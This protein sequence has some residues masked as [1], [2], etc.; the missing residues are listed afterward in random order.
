ML[1][2]WLDYH[3]ET[4]LWKCD[5]LTDEDMRR[6]WL[7]SWGVREILIHISG[8]HD[9][10]ATALGRVANGDAPYPE[11]TY[12]DFDA[13]N[14]RFVEQRE[15]VKTADVLAELQHRVDAM[16]EHRLRE[17]LAPQLA[18][19]ADDMVASAK[20]ELAG[21]LREVLSRAVTQ[22]IARQRNRG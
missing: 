13:W 14:A 17:A 1:D 12:D 4:L 7:G 9:E 11:G 6:V 22:E 19:A 15:G 10:M 2:A 16:L 21:T 5:G 8:W 3:R 20:A 18:K